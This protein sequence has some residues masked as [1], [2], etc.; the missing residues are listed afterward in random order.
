VNVTARNVKFQD[1]LTIM[2]VCHGKIVC[3]KL[4]KPGNSQ[5]KDTSFS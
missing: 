5:N 1:I 3:L 4:K 2:R